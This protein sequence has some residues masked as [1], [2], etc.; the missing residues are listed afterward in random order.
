[1]VPW[2]DERGMGTLTAVCVCVLVGGQVPVYLPGGGVPRF[3][4]LGFETAY[5][6]DLELP[7]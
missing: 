3:L 5:L 1:M 6:T 2:R 7:S 4:H